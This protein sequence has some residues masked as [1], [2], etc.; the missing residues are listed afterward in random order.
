VVEGLAEGVG[1]GAL[2]GRIIGDLS[3][4]LAEYARQQRA[5]V[6]MGLRA[7]ESEVRSL[8]RAAGRD[9]RR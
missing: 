1:S 4:K 2:W 8:R 9:A 3:R 5:G 7:L 6:E